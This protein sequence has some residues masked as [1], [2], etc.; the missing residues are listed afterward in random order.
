MKK[1]IVYAHLTGISTIAIISFSVIS[2]NMGSNNGFLQTSLIS[3]AMA[4]AVLCL[5]SWSLDRACTNSR[6]KFLR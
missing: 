1:K 5:Q 4:C 3:W 6:Q 2:V